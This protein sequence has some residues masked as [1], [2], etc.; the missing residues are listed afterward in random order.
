MRHYLKAVII[1]GTSL[2]V[3][4]KLVPTINFGSDPKN[5]LFMILGIFIIS[6]IIDPIFSLILLPINHLT[7]GL[8]MF[9]LNIGLF[10]ALIKFLPGFNVSAYEFAGVEIYGVILPA[11]SFNQLGAIILVAFI[12]SVSQKILHIIF[13]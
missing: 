11:A 10:Y 3:A 12:I 5:L 9:L 13:E 4:I 8:I 6:Q 7:F 1:S 2:Y